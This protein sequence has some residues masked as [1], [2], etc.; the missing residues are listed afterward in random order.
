MK[1]SDGTQLPK[2]AN[3]CIVRK[4]GGFVGVF[5]LEFKKKNKKKTNLSSTESVGPLLGSWT[6][7][8]L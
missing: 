2:S 8:T 7:M 3:V 1:N 4:G 5:V 6:R